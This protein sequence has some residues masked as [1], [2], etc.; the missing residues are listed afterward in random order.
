[1]QGDLIPRRILFGNPE[2]AFRQI[3]PDGEWLTWVAPA[4]GVMNI[5]IAP[6]ATP[7]RARQLTFDQG[8]GVTAYCW[9]M[10]ATHL[11]YGQD[12][13]GDENPRLY[14]LNIADGS[15]R[16]L[17]P[18]PDVKA[19]LGGVSR[20]IRDMIMVY[21]NDRDPRFHDLY[22][23]NPA[24]GERRKLADNPGFADIMVD[25]AFRPT[26]AVALHPNGEM[27]LLRNARAEGPPA[28]EDWQP[29]QTIPR[30][31]ARTTFPLHLSADGSI[32]YMADS[33][34]RDTAALSAITLATGERTLIASDPRADITETFT[35]AETQEILGYGVSYLV[36]EFHTVDPRA[37]DFAWL[38][39]QGLEN[40]V[41]VGRTEADDI[42]LVG[43]YSDVSPGEVF[44]FDRPNRT[45]TRLPPSSP[46]L[47]AAGLRPMEPHTIPTRDGLNLISYATLPERAGPSERV[48][49]VLVV[50]G[51][52]TARDEFGCNREH[53]WL[54][55]RGYAALSVNFRGSAG[56]GK[57]FVNAAE[58][59]WGRRMDDDLIEAVTWAKDNLPIDPSRIA[60]YGASYGGYATLVGLTRNPDLYACGVDI[61]GPSNLETLLET[62]PPYWEAGRHQ[63]KRMI[64]DP[65][66]AEGLVR[67]RDRSPLHQADRIR[68]PL[69]IAQGANDPRVKRAESDQ[70]VAALRSKA[71]PVT[72]LLFPDE[73]HG[74]E[75]PENTLS[76]YAQAEAFLAAHL[77]GRCEP[78]DPVTR[79]R[80][81]MQ[82]L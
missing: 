39:D 6:R 44:V 73:G 19:N 68:R 3:S 72:Y 47:A 8:R 16:N 78:D 62:I 25:A 71:I 17:T 70:M 66:T 81:S 76:F 51:G 65:D 20:K 54:A 18:E 77:G 63:L 50:H 30:E 9:T 57:A 67:L 7:D 29:W 13:D 74:F 55:N 24:T 53:Q 61:V 60:I 56:F 23:I 58:G 49:L 36:R 59:E 34:G 43:T 40:P 33:R 52:P 5:F 2:R 46:E 22:A 15:V 10:G 41:V 38:A 28:P 1:M 69:M 12:T 37:G 42:W 11:V 27:H 26:L 64:G 32:L 79:E 31:D 4:N 21:L 48:P 80:S 14:A 75:R 35:D 45:L 82:I